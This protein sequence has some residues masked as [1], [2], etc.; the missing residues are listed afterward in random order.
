MIRVTLPWHLRNLA[1]IDS[2][3]VLDVS[4]ADHAAHRA[5]CTRGRIPDAAR[6]HSRSRH[7]KAPAVPAVLCVRRGSVARVAGRAVAGRR[8]EGDRALHGGRRDC[9]RLVLRER[10]IGIAIQPSLADFRGRDHR[11]RRSACVLRGVLVRGRVAAQRHTARL[12]R[13][14]VHPP[15]AALHA[16]RALSLRR[17]FHLFNS[18]NV[19][20]DRHRDPVPK[21][22]RLRNAQAEA[23]KAEG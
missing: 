6:D 12:A 22:N 9:R 4:G 21:D 19:I 5:R 17:L 11:M 23:Y 20:T 3:V 10:V 16:L 2:E 14:E 18:R 13:T 7:R 8:G 15:G 1:R